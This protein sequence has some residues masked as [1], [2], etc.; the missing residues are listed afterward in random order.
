M[1]NGG[2]EGSEKKKNSLRRADA[3]ARS[4]ATDRTEEDQR[5]TEQSKSLVSLVS[6]TPLKGQMEKSVR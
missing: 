6:I 5:K 3:E 1:I 4:R 2:K